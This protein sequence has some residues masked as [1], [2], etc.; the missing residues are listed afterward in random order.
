MHTVTCQEIARAVLDFGG[1]RPWS[2]APRPELIWRQSL[3]ETIGGG[4]SEIMR[5]VV[6]RQLLGLGS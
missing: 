3:T 2:V 6:S 5:S 4:T 1:R